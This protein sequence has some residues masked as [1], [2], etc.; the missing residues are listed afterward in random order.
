MAIYDASVPIP[1]SGGGCTECSEYIWPYTLDYGAGHCDPSDRC[2]TNSYPG[3]WEIPL[4]SILKTGTTCAQN[5]DIEL[6]MTPYEGQDSQAVADGLKWNLERNYNSTRAPFA[7]S[8][9]TS[10]LDKEHA[11]GLRTFLESLHDYE[12]VWVVTYP[13]VIQWMRQVGTGKTNRQIPVYH[14]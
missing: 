4:N 14:Q 3:L 7:I 2:P 10:W 1:R 12:D 9:H 13:Q 6:L 11:K 8:L 5:C